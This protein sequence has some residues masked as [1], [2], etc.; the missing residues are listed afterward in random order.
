MYMNQKY[1]FISIILITFI[2]RIVTVGSQYISFVCD[3]DC[4]PSGLV[5]H[6]RMKTF[7]C[8]THESHDI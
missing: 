4:R 3:L 2:H 7:A 8:H 5:K 6:R 1:I